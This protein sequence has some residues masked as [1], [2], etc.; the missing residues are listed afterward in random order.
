MDTGDAGS[1]SVTFTDGRGRTRRV[2]AVRSGDRWRTT[3]ALPPGSSAYVAAGAVRD[4]FGDLNGRP[5]APVTR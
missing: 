1:A 4:A 2:R 3:A 5:S